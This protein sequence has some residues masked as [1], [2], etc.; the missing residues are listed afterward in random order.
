M[1]Q[2][3]C[4]AG[5]RP[6]GSSPMSGR[7]P[8]AE[9]PAAQLPLDRLDHAQVLGRRHATP[10]R[11]HRVRAGDVVGQRLEPDPL[12]LA[13]LV[14]HRLLRVEDGCVVELRERVDEQLPV[15]TDLG[16]VLVHLRH[17]VERV[18]DDAGAELAHVV[19]ERRAVLVVEVHED[20]ARP[21]LAPHRHE[22]E[23]G[24]VEVE[25]LALLLHERQVAV[26]AVAPAV[27]LA[28]E[29]PGGAA[30]LFAGVV[31]P[32]QLVAAVAADVVEGADLAGHVAHD[33]DRGARRVELTREVAAVAGQL[34]D[35]ADVQ[36][37]AA[38]DGVALELV[39]LG[40]DRVR[41]GDGSGVDAIVLRP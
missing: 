8:R 3:G 32:H 27:V 38:E 10:R 5:L 21:R 28:G 33:D 34:L 35:A 18:V 9:Q 31:V 16:A 12:Q 2:A 36:P 7:V 15:G 4:R 24:P 23:V 14:G 13:R 37:G 30:D 6:G 11:H 40:R 20:E 25:E 41:V 1:P 29:L 19:G 39:V 22:A 26:E 17:A